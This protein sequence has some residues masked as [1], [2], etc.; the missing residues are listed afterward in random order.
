MPYPFEVDQ[1]YLAKHLDEMVDSVFSALQSQFL[2]LHKGSSF[3]EYEDFQD[4]YEVLKRETGAFATF[5]T[6]TVWSALRTDSLCL[7][8]LRTILG[9]TPP[10]WADLGQSE[11]A[12]SVPQGFA[13]SLDARC[14][15]DREYLSRSLSAQTLQRLGALVEVAVE[16]ITKGAPA[17]AENTVHRL[18][19]ADT[20]EGLTSLQHVAARDVPFAIL[21]YERYLGR[22]FASHRDSVSELVGNVM[23]SAI[24]ERLIQARISYR[25]TRRAEKVPGFDQAPDFFIPDEFSPKAVIEAKVTGDDGTARD[26]ATRIIHLA[27]MSERRIRDGHEGFQVIACVDGR[28][29]G[30]RREDMRRILTRTHGKVFTLATV[31]DH[32]YLPG[33]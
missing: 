12:V 7:V 17:G 31:N 23:E 13:R 20:A 16:Y 18:A 33:L 26:K 1:E 19:K 2:V 29:F 8:V 24:E 28:G 5:S 10:E 25:K 15:T 21:L 3:V 30:V 4:A 6:D 11:R 9:M 32:V 22:P 14:R 27:E